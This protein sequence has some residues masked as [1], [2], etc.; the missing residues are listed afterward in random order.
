MSFQDTND[1]GRVRQRPAVAMR[2]GADSN[3]QTEMR[4]RVLVF[5]PDVD[6]ASTL[7]GWLE[8]R[9][10]VDRST[11]LTDLVRRVREERPDLL[12]VDLSAFSS[13]VEEQLAAVRSLD[14]SIPLIVLRAYVS[15]P[16][17][18]SDAIVE[19]ADLVFYKPIDV[20]IVSKSIE[21]LLRIL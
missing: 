4:K 2:P 7:V 9:L 11:T 17:T 14:G 21:D 15:L 1:P 10:T 8:N 13:D 3:V 19:A 5:S 12:L 18:L 20:D 16:K 6:L